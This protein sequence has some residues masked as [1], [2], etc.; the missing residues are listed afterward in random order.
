VLL[1]LLCGFRR[2]VERRARGGSSQLLLSRRHGRYLFPSQRFQNGVVLC[3]LPFAAEVA[4]GTVASAATGSAVVAS[5]G[6]LKV[7]PS[8]LRALPPGTET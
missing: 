4:S 6:S 8:I 1:D 3:V 5:L 2:L 7:T